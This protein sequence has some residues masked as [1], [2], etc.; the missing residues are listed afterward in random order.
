VLSRKGDPGLGP[1]GGNQA[2]AAYY[3]PE[4]LVMHPPPVERVVPKAQ[5]L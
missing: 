1:G 2:T 4:Y 3:D 5:R